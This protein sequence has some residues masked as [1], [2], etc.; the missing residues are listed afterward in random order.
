MAGPSISFIQGFQ[1]MHVL[2]L[3]I[4]V[5][6]FSSAILS[7]YLSMLFYSYALMLHCWVA[8]ARERPNFSI[9]HTQLLSHY[10]DLKK[11]SVEP[12][13]PKLSFSVEPEPSSLATELTNIENVDTQDTAIIN[14]SQEELDSMSADNSRVGLLHDYP[15]E[16]I[17]SIPNSN[18]CDL[19]LTSSTGTQP[20]SEIE[21]SNTHTQTVYN[22]EHSLSFDISSYRNGSNADDESE[23]Y[24]KL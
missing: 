16:D 8:T 10:T 22:F 23:L 4:M 17:D 2:L 15:S 19:V 12:K 6:W 21:L 9:L 20:N 11:N 7:F 13:E 5:T 18:N 14:E 1:C 3:T 24:T